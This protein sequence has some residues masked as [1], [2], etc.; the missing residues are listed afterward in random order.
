MKD[1][2]PEIISILIMLVL[3]VVFS[4][5]GIFIAKAIAT[6]D[7]PEWLKLYLLTR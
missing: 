6:S 2:E 1:F 3:A 4:V 5:V 7:M